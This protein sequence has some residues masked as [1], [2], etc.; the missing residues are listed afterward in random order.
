MV[1]EENSLTQLS[2]ALLQVEKPFRSAIFGHAH[3]DFHCYRMFLYGLFIDAQSAFHHLLREL[4]TGIDDMEHLEIALEQ[5]SIPEAREAVRRA[6]P[7]I[8]RK[9]GASP[10]LILV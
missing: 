4:V 6:E 3:S 7:G 9:L 2:L 10:A 1:E 5:L 8:L